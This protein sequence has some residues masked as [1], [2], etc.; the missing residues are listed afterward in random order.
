MCHVVHS[1]A[2]EVRN[3]NALCFMLEWAQRGYHKKRAGT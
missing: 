2:V 1:S 3:I